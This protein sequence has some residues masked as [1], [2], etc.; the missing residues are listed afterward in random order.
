MQKRDA[1]SCDY[2]KYHCGLISSSKSNHF[3][4]PL[5]SSPTT[6]THAPPSKDVGRVRK[7]ASTPLKQH[8]HR[9]HLPLPSPSA[10]PRHLTSS[11][12]NASPCLLLPSSLPR[13]LT[14]STEDV[15]PCLPLPLHAL[16][17]HVTRRRASRTPLVHSL[18]RH[19][20][21]S[22]EDT[23]PGLPLPSRLF[24]PPI[25]PCHLTSSVEDASGLPPPS[26]LPHLALRMPPTASHCPI[27]NPT[28]P[29][30]TP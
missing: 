23:S 5:P 9:R 16:L 7:H 11:I 25:L 20:T 15:S 26:S 12:K 18:P 24:S 19:L 30:N 8:G 1:Q 2:D 17:C 28:T 21:L 29:R 22:V 14:L 6:I 27:K 4:R 3:L 10:L 13:H